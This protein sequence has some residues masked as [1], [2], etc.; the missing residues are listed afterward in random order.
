LKNIR[1]EFDKENGRNFIKFI[2]KNYPPKCK[3]TC[4]DN[5]ENL[6][7]DQI[8]KVAKKALIDYHEDRNSAATYGFEW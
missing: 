6:L 7:Y 2:Y 4:P 3:H 1:K 5:I 8:K